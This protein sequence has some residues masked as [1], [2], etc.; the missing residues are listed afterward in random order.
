[1]PLKIN[2]KVLW[3]CSCMYFLLTSKVS[4]CQTLDQT[5]L[6]ADSCLRK[7]NFVAAHKLYQRIYILHPGTFNEP[8]LIENLAKCSEILGQN[9]NAY[10]YYK[11]LRNRLTNDSLYAFYVLKEYQ[12]GLISKEYR[13]LYDGLKDIDTSIFNNDDLTHLK[14]YCGL[15]CIQ[16]NENYQA[17]SYFKQILPH[18]SYKDS[19]TMIRLINDY[20]KNGHVN[21]N[22]I[23]NLSLLIPGLGQLA[24][25]DYK[26]ASNSFL[27]NTLLVSGLAITSVNYSLLESLLFWAAPLTHY[28]FG[29][30]N[31]SS[32][33]AINKQILS[34]NMYYNEFIRIFT[35]ADFK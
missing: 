31:S 7:N 14:F 16:L 15:I 22:R 34:N 8:L 35:S 20:K 10:S 4:I 24:L 33:L 11:Q 28:Y 27:L 19:S 6:K 3:L 5:I 30:A 25:K 2:Y 21:N 26:N 18:L 9:D 12:N 23:R 17:I 32:T 13:E 29:G 1:M